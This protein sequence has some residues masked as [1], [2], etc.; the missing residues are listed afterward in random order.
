MKASPSAST[1]TSRLRDHDDRHD[2][3]RRAK[4]DNGRPDGQALA[5]PFSAIARPECAA[6]VP[7]RI[8]IY[9]SGENPRRNG[10]VQLSRPE[11]LCGPTITPWARVVSGAPRRRGPRMSAAFRLEDG[12]RGILRGRCGPGRRERRRPLPAAVAARVEVE[13]A[14]R[15]RP[16]AWRRPSGRCV[17]TYKRTVSVVGQSVGRSI[18]C[19][20][21]SRQGQQPAPITASISDDRLFMGVLRRIDRA[22]AAMHAVVARGVG[23]PT[24]PIPPQGR[25]LRQAA[26]SRRNLDRAYPYSAFASAVGRIARGALDSTGSSS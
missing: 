21:H 13:V 8:V 6:R 18:G 12:G 1:H 20:H 14:R 9:W 22:A 23:R 19:S 16:A 26:P 17:A 11:A 4:L 5:R 24:R 10:V 3:T 7:L 15:Y 2:S 25:N